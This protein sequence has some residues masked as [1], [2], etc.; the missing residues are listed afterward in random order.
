M[1][2]ARARRTF[3]YAADEASD[4]ERSDLDEQEQEELIIALRTRDESNSLFYQ[5][6]FLALPLVSILVYIPPI[7]MSLSGRVILLGL[8]SISSLASTAYILHFIPPKRSRDVDLK[9]KRPMYK[10]RGDDGGPIEQYLVILNLVLSGMV[11]LAAI[12]AWKKGLAEEA[13]RGILPATVF[14]I[15][16]IAR[17]QIA[18]LDVDGLEKLRYQYKGA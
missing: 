1:A 11:A 4:S 13:W 12:V 17:R 10:V 7:F 15:V 6:A 9:G 2:T 5:R 16:M 18:P 3:Q 14:A 8:L